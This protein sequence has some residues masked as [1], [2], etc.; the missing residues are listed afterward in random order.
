MI[1]AR[2]TMAVDNVMQLPLVRSAETFVTRAL[3]ARQPHLFPAIAAEHHDITTA[4]AGRISYYADLKASG[5]PLILL[6]GMH[7][8]ASSYEMGPLFEAF[9]G[10]RKV[11]ALDL[12]GFG[13][14]ARDE[15]EYTPDTFVHAIEHLLRHAAQREP[16][17]VIAL[18]LTSEYAAKVAVELPELVRSLTLISPTGF[19]APKQKSTLELWSR[20]MQ[21]QLPELSELLPIRLF[22]ELLVS[23]HRLRYFLRRSFE[24]RVD[25]GLLAY[26]HATSHQAG[27][28]RAPL[29][30]LMGSLFPAGDPEK[31]YRHVRAPALVIYDQDPYTSFERLESF[32]REQPSFRARRVQHTR[33][34]PQFDA[35]Q[36]TVEALR[37]F[38]DELD[39][40]NQRGISGGGGFSN[41]RFVGSA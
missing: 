34:L 1:A 31:L 13:F 24:R 19:A 15:R 18:S 4:D 35:P 5:R 21:T 41:G 11:Y 6:H 2:L 17:D 37:S 8:A 16:A 27:A 29:A 22:Y 7:A 30:F 3:D 28:H 10:K 36:Q 40:S 38:Y 14:S 23:K 12:P 32:L 33:G 39:S 20:R 25:E 26:A 9:R